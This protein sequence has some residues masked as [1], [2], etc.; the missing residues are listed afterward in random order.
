[1]GPVYLILKIPG[2]E[3]NRQ[4]DKCDGGNYVLRGEAPPKAAAQKPG[5]ES[6][7]KRTLSHPVD[8]GLKCE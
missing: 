5:Q 1:M 4:A 7:K 2:L 6:N 8:W 3:L